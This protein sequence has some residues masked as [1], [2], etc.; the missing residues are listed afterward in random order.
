MTTLIFSNEEM[1]RIMEIVNSIQDR[2]GGQKHLFP[3]D[4]STVTST[5]V[6]VSP[7]S[8]LTFSSLNKTLSQNG[9]KFQGYI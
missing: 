5:N 6:S 1:K 2:S 3:A 9:I 8:F 4:F 7:K